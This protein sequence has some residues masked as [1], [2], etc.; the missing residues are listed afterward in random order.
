MLNTIWQLTCKHPC[1]KIKHHIFTNLTVKTFGIFVSFIHKQGWCLIYLYKKCKIVINL[2]IYGLIT[3]ILIMI[4][5]SFELFLVLLLCEVNCYF[6]RVWI[7]LILRG[8]CWDYASTSY[9]CSDNWIF[10]ANGSKTF[11]IRSLQSAV[12][13]CHYSTI[14]LHFNFI[15]PKVNTHYIRH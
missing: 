4:K 1:S 7:F 3:P 8:S 13:T 15:L 9:Q 5:R 2:N 11:H 6:C 10:Q 12:Q 14:Y